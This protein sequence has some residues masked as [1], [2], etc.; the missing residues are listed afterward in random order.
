MGGW[1]KITEWRKERE[2]GRGGRADKC[3]SYPSPSSIQS[4]WKDLT[5]IGPY[6]KPLEEVDFDLTRKFYFLKNSC[7]LKCRYELS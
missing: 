3:H 6:I 2:R 5:A 1:E 7:E 4:G